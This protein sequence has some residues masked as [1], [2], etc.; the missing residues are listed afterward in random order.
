MP[1]PVR[2]HLDGASLFESMDG[3]P[4]F[5]DFG[6]PVVGLLV[7]NSGPLS[8]KT[9]SSDYPVVAGYS[10]LTDRTEYG[11]VTT[12]FGHHAHRSVIES[13]VLSEKREDFVIFWCAGILL[14]Q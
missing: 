6:L 12:D 14:A 5:D 1:A 3:A 10:R 8:S 2:P 11:L 13:L 7:E 4:R 9:P